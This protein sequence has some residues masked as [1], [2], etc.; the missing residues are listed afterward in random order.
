[1]TVGAAAIEATYGT[2]YPFGPGSEVLCKFYIIFYI[3]IL[4][5]VYSCSKRF[6]K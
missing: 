2:E 1:M 5:E 6:L 3:W 4:K